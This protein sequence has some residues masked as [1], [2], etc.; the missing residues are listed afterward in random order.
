MS[1]DLA[2]ADKIIIEIAATRL[3]LRA[4][5]SHLIAGDRHR[6]EATIDALSASA[7][8]LACSL[9]LHGPSQQMRGAV[10]DAI[11]RRTMSVV[12]ELRQIA[13]GSHAHE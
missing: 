11:R 1:Y 3:V 8:A 6:A 4:A 9:P 5:V 12:A 7:D 10:I 13:G 2:R